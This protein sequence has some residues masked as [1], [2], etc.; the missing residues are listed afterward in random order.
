MVL[1]IICGGSMFNFNLSSIKIIE[2]ISN[3][4]IE[5]KNDAILFE[6]KNG[7]GRI[8]ESIFS[9]SEIVHKNLSINKKLLYSIQSDNYGCPTCQ[10][11]IEEGYG[12][13]DKERVITNSSIR[14]QGSDI[15]LEESLYNLSRLI[16]LYESGLYLITR[17]NLYPTDG[18][19]GFFWSSTNGNRIYDGTAPIVCNFKYGYGHLSYLYPS[20]SIEKLNLEKVFDYY[21]Q[22][23]DYTG[24]VY[25]MDGVMGLLLDGHH[26]ATAACL[27]GKTINALCFAR[28]SEYVSTIKGSI[29]YFRS[30]GTEIFLKELSNEVYISK[31]LKSY[32]IKRSCSNDLI[33]IK[34]IS[35]NLV[36]GEIWDKLEINSKEYPIFKEIAFNNYLNEISFRRL[37][38]IWNRYDEDSEFEFRILFGALFRKDKQT[39]YDYIK[40]IIL[41]SSKYEFHLQAYEYLL[42]YSEKMIEELII[43]Y[44]VEVDYDKSDLIRKR[45][46]EYFLNKHNEV[47]VIS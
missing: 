29:I 36:M 12:F 23:I 32:S 1:F 33:S 17:I 31:L 7:L 43:K 46:D 19:G 9:E 38:E 22:D 25:Y 27:K 20:E 3:D 16:H 45:I 11:I 18:E 2:E 40:K 41:D 24:L 44:L 6:L 4:K 35:S 42:T 15:T 10:K 21:N 39:C 47:K 34:G 28:I 5:W 26:R 30:M 8:Q 37:E 14:A 13:E